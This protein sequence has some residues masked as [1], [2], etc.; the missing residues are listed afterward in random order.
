M[1]KTRTLIK[2]RD[3]TR[4]TTF[5]QY[6]TDSVFPG[7]FPD[8]AD[9]TDADAG[10]T[11]VFVDPARR[12]VRTPGGRPLTATATAT[13]TSLNCV[14]AGSPAAATTTA[15]ARFRYRPTVP[16]PDLV[17]ANRSSNTS[18]VASDSD[19]DVSPRTLAPGLARWA[20]AAPWVLRATANRNRSS[21]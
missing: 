10:P 20:A 2:K 19:L 13:A 16:V 15:S 17:S 1:A 21:S 18:A 12:N 9:P 6:R 8:V 3:T 11:D 5:V 14:P 4:F 7:S